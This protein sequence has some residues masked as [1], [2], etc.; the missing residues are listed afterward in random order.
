MENTPTKIPLLKIPKLVYRILEMYA[1]IK[2]LISTEVAKAVLAALVML[3]VAGCNYREDKTSLIS[4]VENPEPIGSPDPTVP[5]VPEPPKEWFTALQKSVFNPRCVECHRPGNAKKDVILTSYKA[6]M[7]ADP[8]IVRPFKPKSSMLYR[9][10]AH[11]DPDKRMPPKSAPLTELECQTIYNWILKGAPE[12]NPDAL[13][14][15]TDIDELEE[16]D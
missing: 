11:E 10:V 7:E 15:L 3:T 12:K 16:S 13:S 2:K 6:I 14:D 8:P 4:P 5:P 1:G 9:C